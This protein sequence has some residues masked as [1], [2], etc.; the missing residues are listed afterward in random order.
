M[1]AGLEAAKMV[2]QRQFGQVDDYRLFYPPL[3]YVSVGN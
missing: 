2:M 3:Y 1:V